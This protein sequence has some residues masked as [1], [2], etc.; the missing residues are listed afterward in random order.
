MRIFSMKAYVRKAL[1]FCISLI[2]CAGA[3][4][5]IYVNVNATGNNSGTSWDNA[6]TQ[7]QSACNMVNGSFEDCD[8]LVAEGTYYPSENNPDVSFGF[9][10]NNIRNCVIQLFGGYYK[11]GIIW[12]RDFNNHKTIL[13]GDIDKNDV[14]QTDSTWVK[15][16]TNSKCIFIIGGTY[17]GKIVLNGFNFTRGY[18]GYSNDGAAIWC[19]NSGTQIINCNFYNN[20]A[21]STGGA[22][23]NISDNI[24]FQDSYF[25]RNVANEGGAIY[26]RCTTAVINRCT[27][28]K[29]SASDGGAIRIHCDTLKIDSGCTF[30]RCKSYSYGGAIYAELKN[31]KIKGSDFKFNYSGLEGGCLKVMSLFTSIDNCKFTNSSS[32]TGGAINNQSHY[33]ELTNSKLQYDTSYNNAGAVFNYSITASIKSDTFENNKAKVCGGAV[34]NGSDGLIND[35]I[36]KKNSADSSGG[37]FYGGGDT[38]DLIF[39]KCKILDN[40][41]S[42]GGGILIDKGHSTIDSCI[43]E[44][45]TAKNKGGAIYIFYN[46]DN[47]RTSKVVV[48]K[49][50]SV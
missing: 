33:F 15:N 43:F 36:F 49:I 2:I 14:I 27:F 11:N 24:Y 23:Y 4:E 6:F 12:E 29:D 7:L 31:I 38:I 19:K 9:E 45:D 50:I 5:T 10:S 34:F 21:A 25:G 17:K 30:E 47:N 37:A 39:R 3:K 40:I 48:S 41:A 46:K 18:G 42:N 32:F 28:Y 35:C 44:N 13:S 16:G 26:S 20:S 1:L 22:V 8:I